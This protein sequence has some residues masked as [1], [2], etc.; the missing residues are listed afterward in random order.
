SFRHARYGIH[1]PGPAEPA[2][3]GTRLDKA[4]PRAP[5]HGP[6]SAHPALPGA[7]GCGCTE[8]WPAVRQHGEL[9]G[10]RGNVTGRVGAALGTS[11]ERASNRG[12]TSEGDP[13]S[14]EHAG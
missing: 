7:H 2:P 12:R 1:R 13:G 10:C 5:C 14:A 3:D 11:A 9:D 8:K 6:I 4:Q